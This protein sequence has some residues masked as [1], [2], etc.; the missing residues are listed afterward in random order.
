MQVT[1]DKVVALDYTLSNEQGQVLDS[2]QGRGP[3]T[4]IHGVG[5]LI[6]G[7]EKELEGKSA[8]DQV[9]C[10]V[11]PEQAYGQHNP[12]M[13]QK[14]PRTAFRTQNELKPGMQFQAQTPQGSVLVTVTNVGDDEVTVDANHPLAGMPLNFDVKVV[15][16][17]DATAEELQHGHAHGAGAHQHEV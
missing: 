16:V 11:D 5:G 14:V 13:V 9:K 3:L 8:G 1:K 17:R 4:Y 15:D 12:N 6:P 10:R 7:L 2:S